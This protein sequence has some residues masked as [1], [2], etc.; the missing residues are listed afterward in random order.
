M[1]TTAMREEKSLFVPTR[2]EVCLDTTTTKRRTLSNR[3]FLICGQ[4]PRHHRP[5]EL[6]SLERSVLTEVWRRGWKITLQ[7]GKQEKTGHREVSERPTD[8]QQ[9]GNRILR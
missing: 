3:L 5:M 6:A 2:R 1:S 7:S 9:K 8:L 4:N